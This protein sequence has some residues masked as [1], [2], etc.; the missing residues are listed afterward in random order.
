MEGSESPLR[1]EII[2]R[3]AIGGIDK[4]AN[5]WEGGTFSLEW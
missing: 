2:E 3:E 1:P 5:F 4:V